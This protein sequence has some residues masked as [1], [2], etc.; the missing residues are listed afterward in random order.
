MDL[1]KI[2]EK[3]GM[4]QKEFGEYLDIPQRTIENWE[5]GKRTPPEYVINLINYKVNKEAKKMIKLIEVNHGEEKILTKGTLGE[6]LDYLKENENIINWV[7]DEDPE[8]EV[9]K[10]ENVEDV[11]DLKH[12][13]GKINL[14]WW[15][16]EVEEV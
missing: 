13:L 12:E 4:T 2:R 3:T 6:I 7:L 14:S 15:A 10:L 5:G 8:M 1:K 11:R 9:P 16:L